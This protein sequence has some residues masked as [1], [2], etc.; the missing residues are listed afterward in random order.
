[1]ALQG[2]ARGE[3]TLVWV[4]GLCLTAALAGAALLSRTADWQPF[5]LVVT[6]LVLAV[7]SDLL[8]ADTKSL[9]LSGSFLALV[10]AMVL[11]GPAPAAVVG[12]L[13]TVVRVAV[14]RPRPVAA[15][16]DI[17]TCTAFPLLG[18]LAT[19]LIV[20]QSGVSIRDPNFL[21]TV[22]GI[23]IVAN[24]VNFSLIA[25]ASA[26][27]DGVSLRRRLRHDFLPVLPWEMVTALVTV[28]IVAIYAWIGLPALV[29]AAV[30]ILTFQYL[31]RELLT[32]QLRA[33]EL[34]KRTTQLATMQVG[35]LAAMVQTLG[36]RDRMTARHSAAVARFAREIASAA[37]RSEDEQ[38]LVHS[39]GLLHDIGKFALPDAILLGERP[40]DD[41]DWVRIRRH[42]EDGARVV[43]RVDG[44]GPVAD[45]VLLHHERLDGHGYPYGL[46]GDDI[47]LFARMVA[48]ADAY[49]VMTARD[50][51]RAAITS[52]D[53][54]AELRRSAGSQFDPWVVETF[55][56]VLER[57]D[58]AFRHAD[59]ADFE[60]E[61]G[62]ER[63][64]QDFARGRP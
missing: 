48:V 40:L 45:I 2:E 53:A 10:L 24:F 1:V 32:S 22:F 8:E 5:S 34:E 41:D 13:A 6:I 25:Q 42:P 15:L 23:F 9:R 38:E 63:R 12:L 55:I 54:C 3:P 59:D 33:E 50:S 60:R 56:A 7:G 35:V 16:V 18:G 52:G 20:D 37:G 29:L 39:A 26:M 28:A 58:L 51:Y 19:R 31:L 44:Y 11:L 36:L 30:A 47:P 49:D 21:L 43:R 46:S 17:A 61:L 64:V 14:R 62:F 57:R 4:A 27:L